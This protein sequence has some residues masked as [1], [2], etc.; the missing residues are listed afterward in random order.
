MSHGD[1]IE[2]LPPDFIAIGRSENALAGMAHEDRK[3]Y[4][5]Q[6]HPEVVHTPCGKQLLENFLLE[7]CECRADW[8][9]SSFAENTVTEISAQIGQ[10]QAVCGLSGGVD[11]TVAAT[12]VHRA[13]GDRLTCI[14]VD[15][16]LLRKNEFEEVLQELQE[17]LSLNVVGID[18]S[19][20]FL[21]PLAGVEDPEV[22]RKIIG[23]QFIRVFER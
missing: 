14:F 10:S 2:T 6:F 13:I 9:M 3:I 18:A 1:R 19:R 21:E 23:D 11:S 5:L 7:I 16:G 22:K 8:T 20:E 12:L 15:N 17:K 4:G